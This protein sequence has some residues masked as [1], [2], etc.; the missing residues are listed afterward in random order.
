MMTTWEAGVPAVHVEVAVAFGNRGDWYTANKTI[1]LTRSALQAASSEP[2]APQPSSSSGPSG[3][4]GNHGTALF[5]AS[6]DWQPTA[7]VWDKLGGPAVADVK[8]Y[9]A[10]DA[11]VAGGV[12]VAGLSLSP[13]VQPLL[14]ATLCKRAEAGGIG[15]KGRTT[16]IRTDVTPYTEQRVTARR[17]AYG[18][19]SSGVSS[20]SGNGSSS[21][22]SSSTG[23]NN[24]GAQTQPE[25]ASVVRDKS[26]AAGVGFVTSRPWVISEIEDREWWAN[27]EEEEE[28]G[29]GMQAVHALPRLHGWKPGQWKKRQQRRKRQ[30]K[31]KERRRAGEAASRRENAGAKRGGGS[32]PTGGSRGT[33]VWGVVNRAWRAAGREWRRARRR[34]FGRS[35]SK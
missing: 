12:S 1:S 27:R 9:D 35:N 28:R 14:Q 5:T 21:S 22:S 33:S 31:E 34:V 16:A 32:L 29:K 30:A 10:A 8:V 18:I 17:T 2:G 20:G 6:F 25:F 19:V 4:S 13:P 11:D 23:G 15:A 26:A 7:R 3:G 24:T